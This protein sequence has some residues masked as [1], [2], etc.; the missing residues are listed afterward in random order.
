MVEARE[1]FRAHFFLERFE[2]FAFDGLEAFCQIV[3]ADMFRET[4]V[5]LLRERCCTEVGGEDDE[6]VTETHLAPFGIGEHP[7]VED[8]EQDIEHVWVCLLNLV[9]QDDRIG[10]A[11]HLFG[12]FASFSVAD[13]TCWC[14][15]NLSDAVAFHKLTHIETDERAL[16]AEK[17]LSEDLGSERLA[18]AR[19]TEKEE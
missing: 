4:D 15:E 16:V 6:R 18:Y 14:A 3:L 5:C 12:Q 2:H 8:L 19:R 11:P 17:F 9:E 10:F 1:E 7:F 13:I